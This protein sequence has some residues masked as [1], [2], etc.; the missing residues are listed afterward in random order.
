MKFF[1][2]IQKVA[3]EKFTNPIR[4]MNSKEIILNQYH[5]FL[6]N[7]N[8]ALAVENLNLLTQ[9]DNYKKTITTSKLLIAENFSL[10][11]FL[12]VQ[13]EITRL[14]N[15][16]KTLK[17][18]IDSFH[19]NSEYETLQQQADLLTAEIKSLSFLNYS[20]KNKIDDY[21]NSFNDGNF[22]PSH[23]KL[24]YDEIKPSLGDL[25]VNQIEDAVAFRKSLIASRKDFISKEIDTLNWRISH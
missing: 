11:N 15:Q 4:Y 1:L 3:D 6:L 10:K 20:D 25:V 8:N 21:R 5:L 9:L 2:K 17:K 14:D 13:Q 7:I 19:L 16:I 22:N 12:S 18:S 24:I 23:V